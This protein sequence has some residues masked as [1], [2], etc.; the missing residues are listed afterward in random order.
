MITNMYLS[1]SKVPVIFSD[2]NPLN[3]T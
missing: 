2:F 3:K 1:L